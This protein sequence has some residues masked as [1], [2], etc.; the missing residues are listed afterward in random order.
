MKLFR[1]KTKRGGFV[2]FQS[3]SK[4]SLAA[5]HRRVSH[6][7]KVILIRGQYSFGGERGKTR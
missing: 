1:K 6:V 7:N 2:F 5:P 3:D 4:N